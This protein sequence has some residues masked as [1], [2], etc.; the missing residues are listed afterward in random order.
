MRA[1]TARAALLIAAALA[2]ALPFCS[3]ATA[4]AA[5]WASIKP[6]AY[7][8]K[9]NILVESKERAYYQFNSEVPLAFSIEGPTRV[10]ILTRLVMQNDSDEADY[11]VVVWRDGLPLF[12]EELETSAAGTATYIQFDGGRPAAIRRVYI[13]VPTGHHE[14]QIFAAGRAVV[15]ARVFLSTAP[16]PR[17][18]SFAPREYAS[19]ETF[20]HRGKELT[21]YVT[22]MEE[23]V[24]LEV[25]GPTSVKVNTRLLFDPP[26]TGKLTYV[27]G[28]RELGRPEVLYKIKSG[29]STTVVCRDRTDRTP[30]ALRSFMLD[31]GEGSHTY[32]LRLAGDVGTELALKFYIP[33]GDLLNEP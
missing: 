33:R 21:Y 14:Y 32:E 24:V 30:G 9:R 10:K 6:I 5:D 3:A 29:A 4:A 15:D 16:K 31:V 23:S 1:R 26:M 12:T 28:V 2:L 7:A 25:V 17:R 8:S 20:D 27:L 22:T 13:D 18:V 19:V 11:A